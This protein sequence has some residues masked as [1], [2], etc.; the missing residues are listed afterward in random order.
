MTL[1]HTPAA[2]RTPGGD[3]VAGN[4]ALEM[5]IHERLLQDLDLRQLDR[6]PEDE[7][8]QQV[9]SAVTSILA[10]LAPGVAGVTK[11][12]IVK[13]VVNDSIGL[14]PLQP[15][16]DNPDISEIMINAPD[17]VFIEEN[18]KLYLSDVRFRDVNHI[19]RIADRIVQPLGRRLD[20]SSPLV[21]ARLAD[22]SRV[23]I[24]IPPI[25]PESPSITIRKFQ[26]DRF[27]ISDYL[28]LGVMTPEVAGFL[29]AA[30]IAKANI[31]ISG[32][33]G[34]GKT[35]MLNAISTFI[36]NDERLISIED[37]IEIQLRQTH[38]IKLEARPAG[39]GGVG[40]V[41]QG[42][43]VKNALRMRPDRIVVGECRREEAFDMLQAMN[44]GHDGSLTT[45][46]ANSPRDAVARIENMV[47]MA[48]FDLP[49]LA[50][51]QQIASAVNLFLQ[52]TRLQDGSRRLVNVTECLG[53][54][55]DTVTLQDIFVFDNQGPD[56]DG[57]IQGE[58]VSTG[59]RAQFAD[60]FPQFGVTAEWSDEFIEQPQAAAKIGL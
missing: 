55:G 40:E 15:L 44:T 3:G 32:G 25:S 20:E 5:R 46:H 35:T 18:G 8:R 17:K 48:G 60:K 9:Q 26:T 12:M 33:T 19:R 23:N 58:L 54:E 2:A 11:E 39:V 49:I 50:I 56:A 24:T 16:L 45:L 7:R 14:G 59:I 41:T 30:V 13:N 31:V 38:V 21:D 53:M 47:M 37:P 43:L 29:R 36:S 6:L 34:S 10:E 42:D 52:L 1:Q 4:D 57:K 51:R 22:G 28:R 27:G